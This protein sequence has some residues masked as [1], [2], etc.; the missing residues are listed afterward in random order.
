MNDDRTFK[1]DIIL[2]E[3]KEDDSTCFEMNPFS[4]WNRAKAARHG[5][6]SVKNTIEGRFGEVA[7]ILSS[8]GIEMTRDVVDRDFNKMHKSTSDDSTIMGVLEK[9][10]PPNKRGLSLVA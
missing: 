8:Y 9:E 1:G 3:P 6:T 2:I 5:F 7:K 10:S 4:F